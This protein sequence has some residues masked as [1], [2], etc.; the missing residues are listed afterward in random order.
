M[1][2]KRQEQLDSLFPDTQK[3]TV[4]RRYEN[5][6]RLVWPIEK[7]KQVD[8]IVL[9]HTAES[10]DTDASDEIYLKEIYKYHAIAR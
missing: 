5:G 7:T 8:K 9:H 3:L 10:L 1:N 4:I 2:H 6:H